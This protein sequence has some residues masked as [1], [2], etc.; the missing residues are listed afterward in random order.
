MMEERREVGSSGVKSNVLAHISN[1]EK[2]ERKATKWVVGSTTPS[3]WDQWEVLVL[4]DTTVL[5]S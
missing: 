5:W 2:R 3:R 4:E 1:R